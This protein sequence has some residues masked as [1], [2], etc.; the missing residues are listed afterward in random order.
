VTI[1]CEIVSKWEADNTSP[2]ATRR[3]FFP[4]HAEAWS[5]ARSQDLNPAAHVGSHFPF[6]D[7]AII[8]ANHCYP[9]QVLT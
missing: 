1:S 6:F 4:A 8:I 7:A 5:G 2:R 3:A 9:M